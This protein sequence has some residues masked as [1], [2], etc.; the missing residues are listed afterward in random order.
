MS[1]PTIRRNRSFLFDNI[2]GR[3]LTDVALTIRQIQDNVE[4]SESIKNLVNITDVKN[5][6]SVNDTGG[7][8]SLTYSNT[9]GVITYTGPS[10]AEVRAHFTGGTGISINN[11]EVSV[12]TSV[13]ATKS[14]ADSTAADFQTQLDAKANTASLATV[15]TSGSYNDLTD[16]PA[17]GVTTGKAIAMAIVFGG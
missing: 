7:D 3:L 12:D 14:Y 10:A 2:N 5:T 9:S 13:I 11:G 15:A 1:T 6:I 16:K 17:S 8:G 4:G